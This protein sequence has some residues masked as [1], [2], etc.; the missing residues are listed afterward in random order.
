[1]DDAQGTRRPDNPLLYIMHLKADGTFQMRL[2]C[3][4]ANGSWTIEPSANSSS[5]TFEF[6]PLATTKA[7]C[8]VFLT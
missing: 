5:G 8:Q 1:M 2:N 4:N 6:S 3:N 7:N